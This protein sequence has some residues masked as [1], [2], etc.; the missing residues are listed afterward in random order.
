M[1]ASAGNLPKII[2]GGY[3]NIA[4]ARIQNIGFYFKVSET[5]AIWASEKSME[6]S[7]F[8]HRVPND[9]A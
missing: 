9:L 4:P 3:A 8:G 6:E 7:I 1:V 2:D 5:L